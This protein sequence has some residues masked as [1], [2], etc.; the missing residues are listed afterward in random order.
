M[1]WHSKFGSSLCKI[2]WEKHHKTFVKVLE[3]N[4]LYNFSIHYCVHFY[5]TF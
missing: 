4:E 2:R 1:W 3:G 5:S